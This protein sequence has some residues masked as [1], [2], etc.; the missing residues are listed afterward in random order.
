MTAD[1][2]FKEVASLQSSLLAGAADGDVMAFISNLIEQN[3]ELTQKLQQLASQTKLADEIVAEAHK[4]AEA[5]RLLTEKEANHRAAS[6]I[7]ESE[8]KAK[9]EADRIV[10]EALKQSEDIK[11]LKEE[12]ANDRAAAIIRESGAK[13]RLEA[14]R[15]SREAKEQT[16]AIIEEET[17]KAQQY[18]LLI[19]EKAK[20]K[21]ISILE[22]ANAEIL[23]LTS[24]SGQKGRR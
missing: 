12:E 11:A 2:S 13:A 23:A 22:E 14:A 15:I 21:A 4:K 7:S 17:K 1:D 19:I 9:V 3:A 20:E 24:K 16:H 5:I 8:K 10:A 6:I 18:G